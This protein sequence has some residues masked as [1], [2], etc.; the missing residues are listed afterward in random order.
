MSQ[1]PHPQQG[2]DSGMM[3]LICIALVCVVV[4]A[5]HPS[6]FYGYCVLLYYLW[7][8]V[9]FPAI[10]VTV[11]GKMNLLVW[12]SQRSETLSAGQM[13]ELMNQTAGILFLFFVPVAI[14]GII[15]S[16]NHPANRTRRPINIHTLPRIMS[17]FS[18][19]VIPLLQYGDPRTQLLNTD[20][21][22]HRS[23]MSPDE[24]ATK[25]KLVIG[26]R[27]DR[28]R[29]RLVFEAQAGTPLQGPE[30]FSPAERALVA[31]FG[32]QEFCNDRTAAIG[33]LDTLNR[34]CGQPQKE[35]GGKRGYPRLSLADKAF[36]RVMATPKA[37]AWL[38]HH[39]TTRTA[40]SALHARDIRLPCIQFRWLKGLDRTLFYVLASS[41]RPKVFVEGAGVIATAQWE[42]LIADMSARLQVA[43]PPVD[44]P[45]AKAVDG[46]EADLISTGMVVEL[47]RVDPENLKSPDTGERDDLF[48][49]A[50]NEALQQEEP[51]PSPPVA[52]EPD[53]PTDSA[54]SE[55]HA[56]VASQPQQPESPDS[57]EQKQPMRFRPGRKN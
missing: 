20:P 10:H 47:H 57:P 31:V 21:P 29:A 36:R 52:P 16:R 53:K 37:R 18:P 17:A 9:D 35:H 24:F 51:A 46:L 54:I 49:F 41:D 13:I 1:Y 45:T 38:R 48:F 15:I 55:K 27:L 7:G 30:S 22:E 39:S 28:E 3:I 33:L 25:H 5:I 12:G 2:N 26:Q 11:A 4:W 42:T 6:L 50:P 8:I 14:G 44:D 40:L 23:A 43:I 56:P 34:S 19:A 32:L